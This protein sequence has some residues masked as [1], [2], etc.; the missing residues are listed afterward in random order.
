MPRGRKTH[1]LYERVRDGSFLARR[2]EE[3][4]A[5]DDLEW[6]AFAALQASYRAAGTDQERR[7]VALE[8]EKLV[9]AHAQAQAE[10]TRTLRGELA[11]LGPDGSAAQVAAFFGRFLTL[12]NGSPFR[13]EPWQHRFLADAYERD[14]DGRRVYKVILLGIP[15]GNG[16]ALALDTPIPTPDGWT[17]MGALEVGDEVFDENGEPCRVVVATDTMLDHDCY[18][19]VF[20]D[21]TSIV[22][23]AEHL[24]LVRDVYRDE[25]CRSLE[26]VLTTDAIAERHRIGRPGGRRCH[27]YSVPKARPLD[28]PE[29]LLPVEPYVLGAWLGDGE[30]ASGR[31][32]FG[33]P[34]VREEIERCG[35]LVAA[36]GEYGG[37]RA[38]TVTVYGLKCVLRDLGVLGRKHIPGEYLRASYLQRLAL[39]Q[40]LMDTDGTISSP[41]GQC[42]LTTVSMRLASDVVELV[43]S[44]GLKATVRQRRAKIGGRDC[45]PAWVVQFHAYDDQPVFRMPRKYARQRPRPVTRSISETRRIVDVVPVSSVPVRCIGVDSLSHLYLAGEGMVATHNTPLAAGLGL[46]ALCAAPDRPQLYQVAGS[47]LQARIGTDFAAAW[48]QG[49]LAWWLRAKAGTVTCPETGGSFSILSSDGRLSHGRRPRAGI[50]D[51]WWLFQSYRERQA[52]TA[53]ATALHKIQDSWLMAISTAGYELESQLGET[54]REALELPDV[55]VSADGCLTVARDREAGFLM[56]W[57]GAP[58]GAD[59]EDPAVVRACNPGSW[60]DV[61][62]IM[63]ARGR[64]GTDDMEWQRLHVNAWQRVRGLWISRELWASLLCVEEPADGATIGVGIDGALTYDTTAVVW[65]WRASDGRIVQRARVW[66]VREDAPAHEHLAGGRLDNEATAEAFVRGLASRYRVAAVALDRRYLSTEARHLSEAGLDVVELEQHSAAMYDA[67][68]EYYDDVTA[69]RLAHDGDPVFS[70]HVGATAGI[71]SE[72]GWRVSKLR[73]SRPIDATAAAIMSRWALARAKPPARPW[74]TAR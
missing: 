42:S 4:L 38:P 26:V 33:E 70:Q 66:S 23:D 72:R 28:L 71:R 27:R 68:Q 31:V 19:V 11:Q 7:A 62:E 10:Q 40:G 48:A 54:Y 47:K 29:R 49:P 67:T 51:E 64:P 46:H 57:Y 63:R 35:Y 45:G 53:L 65:S 50:V 21:G 36:A 74:A 16:K 59:L 12:E 41:Q 8:F 43:R 34:F 32:T 18:R 52:F 37:V 2:H 1:S 39:L 17:Q 58:D 56:V 55:E 3:L 61:G 69:G 5:G 25:R 9:A 14:R 73:A 24:W 15:R 44:L 13:L 30:A 22:A 6:P 20:S 60:V